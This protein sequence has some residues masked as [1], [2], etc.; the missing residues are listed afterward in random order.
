MVATGMQREDW[1]V[2]TPVSGEVGRPVSRNRCHDDV[3][4]CKEE[5][6]VHGL[7]ACITSLLGAAGEGGQQGAPGNWKGEAGARRLGLGAGSQRVGYGSL[8]GR[9]AQMRRRLACPGPVLGGEIRLSRCSGGRAHLG[10]VRGSGPACLG[11]G[12]LLD[13]SHKPNQIV[14]HVHLLHDGKMGKPISIEKNLTRTPASLHPC[15]QLRCH[16]PEHKSCIV[17][18]SRRKRRRKFS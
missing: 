8:A 3:L 17:K 18:T 7:G 13:L 12:G 11:R 9:V 10:G 15:G 1:G 14:G 16:G 6:R 2:R 4:A 5:D